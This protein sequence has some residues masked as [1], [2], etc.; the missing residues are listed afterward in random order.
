M[1]TQ[2]DVRK[3]ALALPDT[4]ESDG[5]FAFEVMVDGKG[6]RIAGV[7]KERVDPKQTRV[8]NN[9]V[10]VIPVANLVDK[11]LLIQSDPKKFFTEPHYDGYAAVL[12]RLKE[13]KVPELRALMKEAWTLKTSPPKPKKRT[14]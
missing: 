12:I 7:W 9:E 8:P 2:A 10:L 1:A 13:I 6:R 14:S 4:K 3:I 5:A 11:D